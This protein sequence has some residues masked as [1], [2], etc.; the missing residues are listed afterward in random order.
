MTQVS[1]SG[2]RNFKRYLSHSCRECTPCIMTAREPDRKNAKSMA[3]RAKVPSF[4]LFIFSLSHLTHDFACFVP[5]PGQHIHLP[6]SKKKQRRA[7]KWLG[8]LVNVRFW[9]AL[10]LSLNQ[11]VRPRTKLI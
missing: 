9:S 7:S 10:T 8:F 1:S 5:Q 4:P 11:R 2:Y 3:H 6:L